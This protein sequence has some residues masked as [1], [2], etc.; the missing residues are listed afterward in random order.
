M[1]L[2][3]DSL[4]PM[5][6]H[7]KARGI[8]SHYM[9]GN[10]DR[11]H[12]KQLNQTKTIIKED[13]KFSFTSSCLKA[14]SNFFRS[15]W[16]SL[17]C[18][19]T[20]QNSES[21]ICSHSFTRLSFIPSSNNRFFSLSVDMDKSFGD[22]KEKSPLIDWRG[23]MPLVDAKACN[24]AALSLLESVLRCRVLVAVKI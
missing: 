3:I 12:T 21:T 4:L 23:T 18:S 11:D 13:Q 17:I 20:S 22:T 14:S 6:L 9:K 7:C 1:P 24:H 2:C 5:Q 8:L 19:W 16:R 15:S 10:N